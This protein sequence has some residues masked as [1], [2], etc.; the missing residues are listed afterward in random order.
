[1]RILHVTDVYLPRLGGIE[2][3]VADLARAQRLA[4]DTVDILTL[5]SSPSSDDCSVIAPPA[6]TNAW[7]KATFIRRHRT[8]GR[9]HGYDVIHVHCSVISPLCFAT[10]AAARTPTLVTVHS[11]WRRYTALYRTAD[12]ALRWSRLPV[13]WSAVSETAAR[14]VRRAAAS[15]IEVAV[16]PNGVDL[17]AWRVAR[18]P[19]EPDH[20]RI[21]SVM[22][23]A[24]RK[25]PI[26]L[27]KILREV[28]QAAPTTTQLSAT[29][30]GDGPQLARMQRYLRRHNMTGWVTL[31][32]Q[33]ARHEVATALANSDVYVAPATLE[34]FGIAALEARAAGLTVIGR[35]N[36]GLSDFVGN[37]GV[38]LDSDQVMTRTLTEM[39]NGAAVADPSDDRLLAPL[40]WASTIEWTR[41]LYRQAEDRRS[42][43][44]TTG[45]SHPPPCSTTGPDQSDHSIREAWRTARCTQPF[46]NWS[47]R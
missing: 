23:L 9:D 42:F 38:L 32:G 39:A 18:A 27:L 33:L 17:D 28:R 8:Y 47:R 3:H 20:L 1:M 19:R 45:G 5:T 41:W 2:T 15:P 35:A 30:A 7:A 25:R 13:T 29:I 37:G 40:S 16:L 14:S 24:A 12:Y 36:T 26:P 22:R 11:L 44:R 10:I 6:N 31:T 21:I 4:G 46:T 34:S 43:T